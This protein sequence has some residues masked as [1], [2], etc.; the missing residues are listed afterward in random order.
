VFV[1]VCVCVC[2]CVWRMGLSGSE[3]RKKANEMTELRVKKKYL[4]KKINYGRY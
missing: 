2:L 3:S 4:K 1:C